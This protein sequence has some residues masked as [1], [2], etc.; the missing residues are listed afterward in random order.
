METLWGCG[1][2]GGWGQDG[3]GGEVGSVVA[4]EC[5]LLWFRFH[6]H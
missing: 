1:L 5:L 3:R 2:V 4:T 6:S